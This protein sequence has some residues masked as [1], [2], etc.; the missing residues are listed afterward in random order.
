MLQNADAPR[1]RDDYFRVAIAIHVADALRKPPRG[2]NDD[3]MATIESIVDIAVAIGDHEKPGAGAIGVGRAAET[4]APRIAADPCLIAVRVADYEDTVAAARFAG[5][6]FKHTAAVA[7]KI[8]VDSEAHDH[9]AKVGEIV[10]A[11]VK[12]NAGHAGGP[13]AVVLDA[14][15]TFFAIHLRA[16]IGKPEMVGIVVGVALRRV[17]EGRHIRERF[18]GD[19]SAR[20]D[21]AER[22]SGVPAA[23]VGAMRGAEMLVGRR[24]RDVAQTQ[25]QP[26]HGAG[27]AGSGE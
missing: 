14:V 12:R 2:R 23:T 19:D 10:F 4:G 15:A 8:F 17:V 13:G 27:E 5:R 9:R 16:A 20:F 18:F 11:S 7:I 21:L 25:F 3:S 1:A 6:V 24:Q 22:V 26:R